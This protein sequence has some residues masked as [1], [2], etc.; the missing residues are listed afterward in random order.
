MTIWLDLHVA[1]V[2]ICPVS[3]ESFVLVYTVQFIDT[4][5]DL[6]NSNVEK[7]YDQMASL[8]ATQC[9]NGNRYF[10]ETPSRCLWTKVIYRKTGY[11]QIFYGREQKGLCSI[12]FLDTFHRNKIEL[13]LKD[14]YETIT[15]VY[16]SK[17]R[18]L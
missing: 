18:K 10:I 13:R 11:L 16:N 7:C 1:L 8:A 3:L 6:I 12:F 2:L 9:N 4:F 5:Y 15:K 14:L 17:H